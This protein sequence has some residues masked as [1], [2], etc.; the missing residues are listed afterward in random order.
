MSEDVGSL[1]ASIR[2]NDQGF[3][4]AKGR[5]RAVLQRDAKTV[6]DVD[7]FGIAPQERGEFNS[8]LVDIAGTQPIKGDTIVFE[9]Q[10]GGG[11]GHQLHIH[12][13]EAFVV[14]AS[15]KKVDQVSELRVFTGALVDQVAFVFEDGRTDAFGRPGGEARQPFR[16]NA[17]EYISKV[18]TN[19]GDSHDGCS[20]TTNTGRTSDW[21]GGHGGTQRIFEARAGR[22][23]VGFQVGSSGCTAPVLD[24]IQAPAPEQKAPSS[25]STEGGTAAAAASC[26]TPPAAAAPAAA[27]AAG[28]P[29]GTAAPVAPAAAEDDK[30]KK[31]AA[32]KAMFQKKIAELLQAEP[33]L[34]QTE[35]TARVLQSLKRG[36]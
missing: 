15:K 2:W 1:V 3:G 28:Y 27:P 20:F 32:M 5:A 17:G 23:I 12:S 33:G 10:V 22:Q 35:A 31:A 30:A 16:L 34:S 11:G 7:L 24:I 14:P 9:Y 4:N 25:P 21:Y 6:G 19:N 18:T 36:A 26:A 8:Q 13:F 29:A